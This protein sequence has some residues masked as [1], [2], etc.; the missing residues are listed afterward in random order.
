MRFSNIVICDYN[1]T[2]FALTTST[3]AFRLII[4]PAFQ[5]LLPVNCN[6]LYY[7]Y[8]IIFFM[9]FLILKVLALQFVNHCFCAIQLII[10]DYFSHHCDNCLVLAADCNYVNPTFILLF[11]S[12]LKLTI[13]QNH[14]TASAHSWQKL[15]PS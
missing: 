15:S 3:A 1:G 12:I 4:M 9:Y 13:R 7:I 8:C 10:S 2:S 5:R 14:Q 6:C 11:S